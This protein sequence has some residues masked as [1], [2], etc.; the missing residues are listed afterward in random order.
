MEEQTKT[1]NLEE[2]KVSKPD[3]IN[4]Q[5]PIKNIKEVEDG[6]INDIEN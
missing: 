5:E 6:K 4:N 2:I 1:K 3:K